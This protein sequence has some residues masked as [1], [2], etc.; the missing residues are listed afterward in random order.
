M[1]EDVKKKKRTK[2]KFKMPS[3]LVIIF[4]III[5]MGVLQY[6]LFFNYTIVRA[7]CD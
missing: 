1:S 6:I 3:A 2:F 4:A 5:A 7:L